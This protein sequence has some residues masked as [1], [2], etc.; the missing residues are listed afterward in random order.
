[1]SWHS[2]TGALDEYQKVVYRWET[3]PGYT[4]KTWLYEH[5]YVPDDTVKIFPFFFQR[6]YFLPGRRLALTDGM[7]S[8]PRACLSRVPG[9]VS[10]RRGRRGPRRPMR[11]RLQDDRP[12]SPLSLTSSPSACSRTTKPMFDEQSQQVDPEPV[13]QADPVLRLKC[14]P[15]LANLATPSP[16][17]AERSGQDG[18]CSRCRN[19]SD[20]WVG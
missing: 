9:P 12:T 16:S 5:S 10:V 20:C 7:S 3:A 14:P 13:P 2:G 1:V 17:G 18:L 11:R 4:L 6:P 15:D 19:C 8:S